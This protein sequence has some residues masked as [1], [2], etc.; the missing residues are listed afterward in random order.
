MSSQSARFA[1]VQN[2]L[3]AAERY[4]ILQLS[5]CFNEMLNGRPTPLPNRYVMPNTRPVCSRSLN[6]LIHEAERAV[7]AD[8][9]QSWIEE[10]G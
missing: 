5:P 4:L 8:E 7:R 10:N 1:S 9:K 2:N 6:K 3:N